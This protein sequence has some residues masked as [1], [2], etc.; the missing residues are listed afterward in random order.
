MDADDNTKLVVDYR[1][2][3]T[4]AMDETQRALR[5]CQSSA[6][7][8]QHSLEDQFTALEQCVT[9]QVLQKVDQSKEEISFQRTVRMGMGSRLQNYMCEDNYQAVVN[10]TTSNSLRNETYWQNNQIQTL[11]ES[12]ES[13]IKLYKNFLDEAECAALLQVA[14]DDERAK[15]GDSAVAFETIMTRLNAIA[16]GGSAANGDKR[17]TSKADVL[18]KTTLVSS[19]KTTRTDGGSIQARM[20]ILCPSADVVGG[21][22]FF[23]RAGVVVV[24]KKEAGGGGDALLA[25]YHHQHRPTNTDSDEEEDFL[26]EF[27]MCGVRQGSLVVL[28]DVYPWDAPEVSAST[29]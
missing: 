6:I 18:A 23:P 8:Q 28:E 16:P 25:W 22:I 17:F 19:T 13:Q 1:D 21:N 12:S 26:R 4:K 15:D 10:L 14:K 24:P 3:R 2:A 27:T 9:A 5:V 11:F 29:Q 7:T 20:Q